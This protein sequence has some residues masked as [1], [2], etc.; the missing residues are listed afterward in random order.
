M[1]AP[2]SI[3]LLVVCCSPPA[4]FERLAR[5]GVHEHERPRT[6]TWI[7]STTAVRERHDFRHARAERRVSSGRRATGPRE[8][9]KWAMK[10][11]DTPR[12]PLM[13]DFD[14]EYVFS[15]HSA[16]PEKLGALRGRSQRREEVRASHSRAC[17]RL[18]GSRR[19]AALAARGLDARLLG[20]LARRTLEVGV[21]VGELDRRLPKTAVTSSL[22]PSASIYRSRLEVTCMPSTA[23]AVE[24]MPGRRRRAAIRPGSSDTAAGPRGPGRR[25]REATSRRCWSR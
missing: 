24:D 5:G 13:S 14:P 25:R 1:A 7:A 3:R 18:C 16:T 19:R 11:G 8:G 15:H 6:Y 23:Y 2:I 17:S 20:H 9:R 12:E 21:G 4:A 22:P 10:R